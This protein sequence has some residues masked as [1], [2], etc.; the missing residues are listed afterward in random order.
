MTHPASAPLPALGTP[1]RTASLTG[2][3]PVRF[4][5]QPGAEQRDA[6][7]AA[8]GLAAIIALRFKGELRPHGKADLTLEALLEAVVVQPCVISLAPVATQ[9]STPVLRK[10]LH[11][12]ALPAEVEAEMPEDDTCEPLPEA[13]D[14]GAVMAEALVL[15][16]PDYPRAPGAVHAGAA[17]APPGVAPLRDGDVK[18]F[19]ALARRLAGEEPNGGPE[20]GG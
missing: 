2:R 8:L 18:P 3:K 1:V 4:D 7:A 15:A 13:I 19:A 6:L 12:F 16:V 17:V 10:Y 9:I 11:D 14:P 20:N 5:L